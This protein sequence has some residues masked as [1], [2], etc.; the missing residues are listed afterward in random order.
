[1][2]NRMQLIHGMVGVRCSY[3]DGMGLSM[4]EMALSAIKETQRFLVV[5][6]GDETSY[7]LHV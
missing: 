5:G 2:I 3:H 4:V 7:R 6:V 1:M